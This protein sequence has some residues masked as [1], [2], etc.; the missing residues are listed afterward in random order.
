MIDHREAQE[1]KA[2]REGRIFIEKATLDEFRART[3]TYPAGSIHLW[4]AE[5]VY[6]PPQDKRKQS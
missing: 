4:A 5:K 1:L 2:E 3:K 6:G